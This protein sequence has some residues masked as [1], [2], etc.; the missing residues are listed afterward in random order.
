MESIK[1]MK[2]RRERCIFGI[3]LIIA[4]CM[5]AGCADT[6]I[7]AKTPEI[8]REDGFLSQETESLP[9]L[10]LPEVHEDTYCP[11]E[12]EIEALGLP[13][14]M[15]AYWM[16]LNNKKQFICNNVGGQ[17]FYLNE[18]SWNMSNVTSDYQ[19]VR[20]MVVD[21]DGD[22][23]VEVILEAAPMGYMQ[24]LHYEDGEVYS[25][26][27][28]VRAMK[29]IRTNGIYNASDG[30]T[31]SDWLRITEWNKADY[32]YKEE[33]L[34]SVNDGYYEIGGREATYEEFCD[35]EKS[36]LSV[37]ETKRMDFTE[38]MVDRQ[39]LGSLSEQEVAL[40]KSIPA[41]YTI[42]NDPDYQEYK[43]TLQLYA[44]VL[45]GEEEVVCVVEDRDYEKFHSVEW[46]YFSIADMDGDGTNELV[47]TSDDGF[48]QILHYEDGKVYGYLLKP[49][50]FETPIITTDGVFQT[51]EL[52]AT[53]YARI[54]SLDKDGYRIEPVE[55]YESG[56]YERIRY[57]FFSEDVMNQW[58]E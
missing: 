16:V 25:Y 15:L 9:S 28:Y 27:T 52:S 19:V 48:I 23:A 21:M 2:R 17:K 39:F 49:L 47:F 35:Y 44:G 20:F 37:E 58:L 14:D 26:P 34:A 18:Y 24:I 13:E 33:V 31:S 4:V 30:A 38:S 36:I 56:D 5:T 8:S 57:I 12:E 22:G 41:E 45:T 6:S 40:V 29:Q 46:I 7:S 3:L 51:D 11:S 50:D 43:S 54:V 42:E 1:K 55:D 10:T 53:G 32:R